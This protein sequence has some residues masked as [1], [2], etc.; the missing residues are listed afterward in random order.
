MRKSKPKQLYYIP[1]N[2][3]NINSFNSYLSINMNLKQIIFL[4]RQIRKFL[5]FKK[6]Q[7]KLLYR[8]P[9]TKSKSN[10]LFLNN[11]NNEINNNENNLNN[12]KNERIINQEKDGINLNVNNPQKER[13]E[14]QKD[15]KKKIRLKMILF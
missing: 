1:K 10:Y 15:K 9:Q 4:Q 8:P 14:N 5:F 7:K 2:N 11:D 12:I 6:N 13:I 3:K